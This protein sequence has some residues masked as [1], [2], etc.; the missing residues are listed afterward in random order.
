MG[1]MI[2]VLSRSFYD[3]KS[4]CQMEVNVGIYVTEFQTPKINNVLLLISGERSGCPERALAPERGVGSELCA[5]DA[6]EFD[7]TATLIYDGSA[8][9]AD[10]LGGV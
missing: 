8:G 10:V 3:G 7:I 4:G 5:V 9:D 2:P 1:A 6:D